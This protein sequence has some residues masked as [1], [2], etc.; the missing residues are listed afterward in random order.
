MVT[1]RSS[2]PSRLKRKTLFRGSFFAGSGVLLL[3]AVG[4]YSPLS[5]LHRWGLWVFLLGMGL[6]AFG[7]IPYRRLCFLETHPHELTIEPEMWTVRLTQKTIRF[8]PQAICS[9]EYVEKKKESGIKLELQK[10]YPPIFLSFFTRTMFELHFQ[11]L[12]DF[13]KKSPLRFL[14][15]PMQ[16]KNARF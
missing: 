15:K 3:L 5:F 8:S 7:L 12:E 6:I 2:I 10:P 9:A 14:Q 11:S 1:L 16:S 13:P 4:I